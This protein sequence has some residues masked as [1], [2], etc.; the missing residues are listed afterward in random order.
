MKTEHRTLNSFLL[1]CFLL[2]CQVAAGRNWRWEL[3]R[4]RYKQL[5]MFERAQYDKAAELFKQRN[6]R[7]ASSEFE[8][9]KVQFPDSVVLAYIVFMRGYSLHHAKQRYAAIKIYNEV[10]DYFGDSI[11]DAAAAL[12]SL[13]MAHLDNGDIRKG[14]AAMKEM[15]DD[16]D[17][18]AHPLAAGAIRR[19]ADNQWKNKQKELAV[20]YWKQVVRDFHRTNDHETRI[21]RRNVCG[22]YIRNHKYA[23]FEDWL[24]T[25]ENRD[26]PQHR[27][28]VAN[29][30]WDVAWHGFSGGWGKYTQFNR[31]VKTKDMK[32]FYE[33][34]ATQK[35]WYLKVKDP[36]GYYH[37][38]LQFCAHRFGERGEL[39][40]SLDETLQY[41]N[42]LGKKDDPN[43]KYSWLVDRLREAR[44]FERAR[45]CIAKITV[46]GLAVY[47]EYEVL[48]HGQGKWREAINK[49]LELTKM[50]DKDWHRRAQDTL[51][52][53]YKDRTHEYDKAIKV[54]REIGEPPGT[55]WGIQECFHRMGKL[56][57]TLTTL[58]EIENMFPKD[59]PRAAWHKASYYREAGNRKLAIGHAR[60]I[61]KMYKKAH[62]AS[63]AHQMLEDFGVPTGGGVVDEE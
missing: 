49:L 5:N 4:G 38:K 54:Y 50:G 34:F 22:Y 43:G 36:W 8:K 55:L 52:W 15:A 37:R 10:L 26:N 45:Y 30:V 41:I 61:L 58:N 6:Y 33:Y 32:A 24:I 2:L 47:K 57:E 39:E 31:K 60:R 1:L 35:A 27:R 16:E 40:K 25:D 59:A 29:E 44:R 53:V 12:Y 51:A 21:A 17:Y 62:E 9:F 23:E 3:D 28:W 20:K 63:L 11:N 46:P 48:G 42:K 19:L 13:G 56:K 7:A 18:S 14:M